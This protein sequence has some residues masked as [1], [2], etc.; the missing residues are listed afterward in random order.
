M[1]FSPS[2]LEMDSAMT[3]L[4]MWNA[5]GMEEIVAETRSKLFSAMIANVWT[6]MQPN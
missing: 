2:F 3:S 6:Q 4:I 1:D 5:N